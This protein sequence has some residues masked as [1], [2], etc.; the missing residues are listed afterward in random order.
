TLAPGRK[1]A[2]G[3]WAKYAGRVL[4]MPVYHPSYILRRRKDLENNTGGLKEALRKAKK[5]IEI[6]CGS[7]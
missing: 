3:E 5:K 6:P 1:F 2:P 4:I 7:I